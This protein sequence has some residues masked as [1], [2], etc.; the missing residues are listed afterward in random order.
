MVA[1]K[2]GRWKSAPRNARETPMFRLLP[3]RPDDAMEVEMLLDLA[4]APGRQLLSSYRL[5]EGVPPVAELCRVVR[6]EY[7]AVVGAIRFW[8]VAIGEARAPALLLGPI[9]VHPIRQGEGL[10]ALM[11]E[12]TLAAARWL[13]W[14]RVILVGDEPYYSRF[15]F[16][17]E[18][19]AALT[20]PPPTNAA[21][22]LGLALTPGAFDGIAGAVC[23]GG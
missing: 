8:P 7:D 6:D 16:R 18:T 9:A 21:R 20:F 1:A 4:F 5:R 14:H 11:M 13:G 2:R 10:G 17:R 19:A 3:E 12:D 23:R 15:G 22:V